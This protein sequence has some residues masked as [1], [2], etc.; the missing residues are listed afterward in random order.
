MLER[1]RGFA[2]WLVLMCLLLTM[3]SSVYLFE[4][5]MDGLSLVWQWHYIQKQERHLKQIAFRLIEK[6]WQNSANFSMHHAQ[7]FDY[8]WQFLGEY[9]C[10]LRCQSECYGT[11]HWLLN[12]RFKQISA[13]WRIALINKKLICPESLG[14]TLRSHILYYVFQKPNDDVI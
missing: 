8:S 1:Q 14:I 3:W 5:L 12:L 4:F 9:P 10:V 13:S 7:A 11:N 2:L 6:S